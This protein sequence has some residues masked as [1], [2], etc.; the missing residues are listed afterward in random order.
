MKTTLLS[1]LASVLICGAAQAAASDADYTGRWEVTTTYP[2]YFYVAGLE[3][4]ADAN[5]YKGR[6]GYLIPGW[7]FPFKYTGALQKDGL[8]LQIF[9][10]D[11]TSVMGAL[12]LKVQR[13]ALSGTGTL[14]D[15]PITVSGRRPLSRPADAPTVHVFE[16]Q[17]FYQ[18][19]SGSNPP[20]LH[21]FPGDTVRTKTVDA[22]GMDEKGVH[23][24]LAGNAQT[25]PFYIEGAMVGDT[26]AVHFNKIRPNRDTAFQSRDAL[27]PGTLTPGYKQEPPANWSWEWKLDRERGTATPEE[28]SDKLKGFTVKLAPILGCVGVAPYFFAAYDSTH[29]GP[30]GGNLDYNQIR[31][32]TTLY[33]PVYVAGALL[34][35]GDG[36]AL[37]AD[38]ELSG[39]GLEI[40]MDVEFTVNL[41]RNQ[42]LDQPWAENDEY[43]MVSGIGGSMQEALQKATAG[44]SNWLKS[45]YGLNSAE[46]AT[47]LAS[48]IHYDV[49]EVVDNEFHIAAKI[50]KDILKQIPKAENVSRVFC[51][52]SWGCAN[53]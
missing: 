12:V 9:A 20:A 45:Y 46:V 36:H 39:Q 24:T 28:P 8:H 13:G 42:L 32:G 15:I 6:S 34:S 10:G 22:M 44:L 29:L 7:G 37:Q 52:A 49:A 21:I 53:D 43:I 18:T 16:P 41:V 3:L 50:G 5:G 25:G 30:F 33:L 27:N 11:G 35:I 19:F 38:G 23:R 14:H 48:S 1:L 26:I 51:Q 31:E 2:G 17:V 4:T 47:V 40:S